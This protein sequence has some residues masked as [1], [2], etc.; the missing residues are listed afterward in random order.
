MFIY[1]F[2]EQILFKLCL[3]TKTLVI[4]MQRSYRAEGEDTPAMTALFTIMP[5]VRT[6]LSFPSQKYHQP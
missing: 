4:R 3:S 1:I 5:F 2:Y 6:I